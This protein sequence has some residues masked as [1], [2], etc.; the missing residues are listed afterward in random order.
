MQQMSPFS[1]R[2][3]QRLGRTLMA[4]QP[5]LAIDVDADAI[6][7]VNPTNN[8]IAA[9]ASPAQVRGIP[10]T[11]RYWMANWSSPV[12]VM[13]VPGLQPL[14]I[15]CLDRSDPTPNYFSMRGP[16]SG[17]KYSWRGQVEQVKDPAMYTVSGIDWLMLVEK[18][19]LAPYLETHSQVG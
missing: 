1:I 9:S 15:S 8:A 10:Q 13:N 6:R 4:G 17:P 5:L 18:C 16:I 7:V 19:G 3:R 12:L 2:G 14:T 11:Y